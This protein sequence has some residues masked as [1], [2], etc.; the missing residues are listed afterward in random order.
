MRLSAAL[1]VSCVLHLALI[2]TPYPGPG[3]APSESELT[4]S[5]GGS[6]HGML[7][8]KDWYSPSVAETPVEN[9]ETTQ[10]PG[11]V[12][13]EQRGGQSPAGSDGLGLLAIPPH[14]YYRAEE[15]TMHPRPRTDPNLE[16]LGN[17]PFLASGTVILNLWIDKRGEV[18]SVELEKTDL[19]EVLAQGAAETFK[20]LR[21]LPGELEG[22]QVAS[23]MRIEVRYNGASPGPKPP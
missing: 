14:P 11:A 6:F 17:W 18:I 1:I 16:M 10:P 2:L 9:K 4:W 21:F 8:Y 15:L 13:V 19:P 3:R 20:R 12:A 5:S 7:I 23:I 22:R